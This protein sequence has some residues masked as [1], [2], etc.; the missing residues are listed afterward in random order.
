MI[1]IQTHVWWGCRV[2]DLQLSM[3][4]VPTTTKNCEFEPR[5]WQDVLDTTLCDTFCQ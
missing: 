1:Y 2:R 3:Q 4:S 5:S